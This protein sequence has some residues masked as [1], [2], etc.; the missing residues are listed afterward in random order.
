MITAT[1]FLCTETHLHFGSLQL[2]DPSI[3]TLVN[4]HSFPLEHEAIRS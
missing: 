3:D 4:A 1:L 2:R